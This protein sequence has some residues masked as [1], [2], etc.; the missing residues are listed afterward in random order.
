MKSTRFIPEIEEFEDIE[1]YTGEIVSVR[2]IK[3]TRNKYGNTYET[4]EESY[5]GKLERREGIVPE[6]T[7]PFYVIEI[8]G[9]SAV[10]DIPSALRKTIIIDSDN[11]HA[12]KISIV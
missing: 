1:K 6:Y 2:G 3:I 7:E 8:Y 12:R 5:T 10:D 11:F 9:N 4:T